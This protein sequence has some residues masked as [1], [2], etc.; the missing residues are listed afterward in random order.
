MAR[1]YTSLPMPI[2]RLFYN[3]RMAK[4]FLGIW[5]AFE[6]LGQTPTIDQSLGMQSAADAQISPDGRYVAYTLQQAN[7][8]ENEFVQQI[9][10]ADVAAGERYQLTSS[11]KSSQRPR[12]SPDSKRLAF[13]SERDGKR[14]IYLI[15]PHGGEAQPITTEDNG[16]VSFEWA[17]DGGA[18][19]FSSSGP[20]PKAKK[21]R[22]EKYGDFE[23]VEGDYAP[24][25]LWLVK[26]PAEI[27]GDAGQR[28]KPELLTDS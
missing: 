23:I 1:D 16:V 14:Q 6:A 13:A 26:P 17:P 21:D 11:K 2:R 28:P 24:V 25:R 9:W 5:L 27:P 3:G 15:N 19:A 18:I 7:W 4:L 12:W 10:I 8:D 20:D 22:K